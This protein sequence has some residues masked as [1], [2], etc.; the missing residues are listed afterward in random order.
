MLTEQS[1]AVALALYLS[2]WIAGFG[3]RLS[4]LAQRSRL[5]FRRLVLGAMLA[6]YWHPLTR[7][8]RRKRW[9]QH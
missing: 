5:V 1:Y 9:L 6:S 4:F 3:T 7:L 8:P 2:N